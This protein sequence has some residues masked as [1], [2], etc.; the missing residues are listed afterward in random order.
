[1]LSS[2][3]RYDLRNAKYNFMA[4][5]ILFCEVDPTKDGSKDG[6]RHEGKRRRDFSIVKRVDAY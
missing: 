5:S 2:G 4:V 1:M 6:A 3:N